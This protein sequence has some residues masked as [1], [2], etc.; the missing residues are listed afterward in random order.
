MSVCAAQ[1]CCRV[2]DFSHSKGKKWI[3][4]A[5]DL[6]RCEDCSLRSGEVMVDGGWDSS[7]A[8]DGAWKV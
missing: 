6:E 1:H 7:G 8:Q 5:L 2:T 3:N 4:F